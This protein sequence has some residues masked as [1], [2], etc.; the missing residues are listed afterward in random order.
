LFI[1]AQLQGVSFSGTTLKAT[2]LSGAYLWRSNQAGIPAGSPEGTPAGP[3][4]V[5]SAIRMVEDDKT[6]QPRSQ[7]SKLQDRPWDD[8]AYKDLRTS[9]QFLPSGPLRDAALKR[10]EV[11][12]CSSPDKTIQSCDPTSAP[13][14]EAAGWRKAVVTNLVGV[15]PYRAALAESLRA[16]FCPGGEDEALVVAPSLNSASF[17]KLVP[18][19]SI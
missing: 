1:G 7:D 2:D 5:L 6:W 17:R 9:L 18:P 8:K 3:P 12:D 15:Q 11:L 4:A 13:P 19:R 14:T 16:L 10:I